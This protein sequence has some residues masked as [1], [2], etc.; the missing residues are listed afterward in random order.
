MGKFKSMA[1]VALV[2]LM[3]SVGV[4]AETITMTAGASPDTPSS[5]TLDF[6]ANLGR[7]TG[8][9]SF[10]DIELEVDPDNGTARFV[11]Y[12]Q[13]VSALT[14]PGGLSTGDLII[15]IVENSSTGTYNELTG[16]VDTVDQ[17]AIYFS[18]DLSAFG[19]QSPVILPSTSLGTV[20]A[21]AIDGGTITL[22]WAGFG[23]LANPFDP[24]NPIT[25]EYTCSSNATFES[26]AYTTVRIGLVPSVLKLQ[27]PVANESRLMR[28]LD[29]ALDYL[30]RG[31]DSISAYWLRRF[32]NDVD[33]MSPNPI[34]TNTANQL[35]EEAKTLV[36][37]LGLIRSKA[38]MR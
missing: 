34:P 21:S 31:Y 9:I 14:L 33:A 30:D 20:M 3:T 24:S 18:G 11:H 23:Q 27:L 2:T 1:I 16:T 36:D 5:F 29:T 37:D 38:G 13:E 17:Y 25:F 4:R 7:S 15:E 28:D 19:L 12:Y 10:M 8:H 35:I 6:G 26:D 22:D 32:A